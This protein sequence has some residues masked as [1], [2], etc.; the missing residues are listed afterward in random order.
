MDDG[1][2]ICFNIPMSFLKWLWKRWMAIAKPIGNFQSQVIISAFY[3]V[4]LSIVGIPFRIFSDPF[5]MR[6]RMKSN[7]D[8]WEHPKETLESARRQY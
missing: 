6:G 3:L 7:F 1:K 8:K 5:K 2:S 4:F